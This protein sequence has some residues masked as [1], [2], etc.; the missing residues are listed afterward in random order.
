MELLLKIENISKKAINNLIPELIKYGFESEYNFIILS[1]PKITLEN[2]FLSHNKSFS[3]G[4]SCELI[5]Q[6]LITIES[7]HNNNIIHRDINPKSLIIES[8]EKIGF[9]NFG[10]WKYYRNNKNHIQFKFYKDMIGKNII[11]G[12]INN[13]IGF[14]LSRRDDLQ[15][16]AY[17]L[18]YFIKGSLPWD[19]LN[20]KKTDEKI[21][22]TLEMK[23][24]FNVEILTDGLPEE[25]K[26]FMDYIKKLKFDEDPNYD[27]L[28]KLLKTVINSKDSSKNYYFN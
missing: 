8:K 9:I 6:S 12:S 25:I 24:N 11:F 21:K 27:Y 16:L 13:L 10:F 3:I 15:S 22:V 20:I 17:M 2:L 5:L 26:L 1:S 23:K 4:K 19:N 18:I 14:E 7:L 28:K